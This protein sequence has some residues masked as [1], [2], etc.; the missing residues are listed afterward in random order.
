MAAADVNGGSLTLK[1]GQRIFWFDVFAVVVLD[2]DPVLQKKETTKPMWETLG[3]LTG[4]SDALSEEFNV[5]PGSAYFCV[6]LQ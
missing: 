4:E 2:E 6:S 5:I 3:V 1:D